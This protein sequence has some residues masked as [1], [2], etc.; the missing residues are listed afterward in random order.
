M[1]QK[2]NAISSITRMSVVTVV[3]LEKLCIHRS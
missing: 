3:V 1:K 2:M